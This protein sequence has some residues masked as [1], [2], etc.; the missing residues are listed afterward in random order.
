MSV[1]VMPI[2]RELSSGLCLSDDVFW[3][4]KCPDT[5]NT[6]VNAG[7]SGQRTIPDT[8]APLPS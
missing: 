6:K 3:V 5:W 7:I 8:L 1:T 2:E 4:S